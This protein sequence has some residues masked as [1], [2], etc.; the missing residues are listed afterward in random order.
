MAN[1]G[2]WVE[3]GPTRR[4][5]DARGRGLQGRPGL[6]SIGQKLTLAGHT[7]QQDITPSQFAALRQSIVIGAKTVE[8]EVDL[9]N[10][11]SRLQQGLN[12]QYAHTRSLGP[13][14]A[15]LVAGANFHHNE[16]NV[17]L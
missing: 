5:V 7:A 17:G 1:R 15:V 11:D 10:D 12:T 8:P 4:R 3:R 2:A 14:A 9:R 13:I 6:T 16:I